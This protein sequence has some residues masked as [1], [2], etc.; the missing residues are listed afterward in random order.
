MKR[1]HRISCLMRTLAKATDA[2]RHKWKLK[3]EAAKDGVVM[4]SRIRGVS[5]VY[6]QVGWH[7][8]YGAAGNESLCL[9]VKSPCC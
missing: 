2:L 8:V 1:W 4:A 5:P 7:K 9:F 6:M 3:N